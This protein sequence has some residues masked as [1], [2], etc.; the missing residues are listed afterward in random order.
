MIYHQYSGFYIIPYKQIKMTLN[1]QPT[2]K[3]RFDFRK[4]CKSY[5]FD[6]S[7]NLCVPV[8]T[9]TFVGSQVIWQSD[10]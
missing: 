4:I 5:S 2:I 9:T 8:Q 7:L 1:I 6:V 3:P 10:C